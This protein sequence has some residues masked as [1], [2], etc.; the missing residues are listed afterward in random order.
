MRIAL[1][2]LVF[3]SSLAR[4]DGIVVDKVYHPYILPN[5][6]EIEWRMLSRKTDNGDVIGQRLAFGKALSEKWTLETYLLTEKQGD[7]FRP[8]A[9]EIELRG[10]LTEQGETWADWGML[11]EVEKQRHS[12]DWE[13]S[14][15]ILFEKEYGR[16]SLTMNGFVIYEWGQNVQ[17]EIET[18]FRLKYRYRWMPEIQPAIELY[19]GEDFVGIG[20]AMMGLVRIQGQKQIKWEAGY[21][22]E[23]SQAGN[24]RSIR[25][26]IEYEF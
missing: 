10:M 13:V 8:S 15:G 4:A 11:F 20:P 2:L 26:A 18:E 1:I 25:F 3:I 19:A 23:V 7:D 9:Y 5:E 12:D 24:D 17:E 21:I 6:T 16:T 14:T 22:T